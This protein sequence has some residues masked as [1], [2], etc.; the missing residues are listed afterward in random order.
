MRAG[1]EWAGKNRENG[2]S[3]D[4]EGK[5]MG[6]KGGMEKELRTGTFWIKGWRGRRDKMKKRYE[7]VKPI[8]R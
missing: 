1:T 8:E 5:E 6:G 2:K 7:E 4:K 3:M